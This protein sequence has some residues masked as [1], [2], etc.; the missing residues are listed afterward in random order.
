VDDTLQVQRRGDHWTDHAGPDVVDVCS[1]RQIWI[2]YQKLLILDRPVLMLL[3]S[4]V[5]LVQGPLVLDRSA[6]RDYNQ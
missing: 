4:G 5:I 2:E 1:V 6:A 3:A